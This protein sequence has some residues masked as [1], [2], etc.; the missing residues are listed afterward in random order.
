MKTPIGYDRCGKCGALSPLYEMFPECEDCEE[1]ICPTCAKRTTVDWDWAS[2]T[3]TTWAKVVCVTC[4]VL[5]IVEG[6]PKK[7]C[8]FS[9]TGA[10]P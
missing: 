1:R 3:G 2:D 9:L 7:E 4:D 6:E 10:R 5:R 8:T